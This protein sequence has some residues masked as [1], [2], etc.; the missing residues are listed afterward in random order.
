MLAIYRP[1][2]FQVVTLPCYATCPAATN[3]SFC[4]PDIPEADCDTYPDPCPHFIVRGRCYVIPGLTYKHLW[5]FRFFFLP[6]KTFLAPVWDFH[7]WVK[8]LSF[9]LQSLQSCIG[10][11]WIGLTGGYWFAE[12]WTNLCYCWDL[13]PL[14]QKRKR[15][16]IFA[17][18][19]VL[20]HL[21]VATSW[22]HL[23][24]LELRMIPKCPSAILAIHIKD[25]HVSWGIMRLRTEYT[26]CFALTLTRS[27]YQR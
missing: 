18:P 6:K 23:A 19:K 22:N 17:R 21:L 7:F 27:L 11:D 10:L 25:E 1:P 26:S 8:L 3:S 9:F 5:H 4:H 2:S 13:W 12:K 24:N 15:G 16:N 14:L 20:I